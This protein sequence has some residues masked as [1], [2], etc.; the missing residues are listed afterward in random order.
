MENSRSVHDP[1]SAVAGAKKVRAVKARIP[2]FKW[3]HFGIY[4]L[5][6]WLGGSRTGKKDNPERRA[7]QRA[8]ARER[9]AEKRK[10]KGTGDGKGKAGK[11][12]GKGWKRKGKAS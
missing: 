10:G 9:K 2:D 8:R 1:G 6:V 11:R 3:W 12:K 5:P 7:R 4:Q